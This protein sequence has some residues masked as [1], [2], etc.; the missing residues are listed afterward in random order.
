[1]PAFGTF[2]NAGRN[3]V[4]GPDYR[5]L[6]VAAVKLVPAGAARVQLRLEVFNVFNRVNFDLPDAFLGSPTFGRILS[7]GPPRRIQLG[8]RVSF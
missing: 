3:S 1:M 5:N 6:S 2:G 7:A 8:A 4:E